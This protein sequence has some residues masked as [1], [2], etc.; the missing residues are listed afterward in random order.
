MT[1]RLRKSCRIVIQWI[2]FYLVYPNVTFANG[3]I[4]KNIKE[5]YS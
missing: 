5:L 1:S 2:C 4:G 3:F